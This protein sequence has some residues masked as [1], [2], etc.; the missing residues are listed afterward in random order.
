MALAYGSAWE[1]RI[2]DNYFPKNSQYLINGE[3]DQKSALN[4]SDVR[5]NV[6]SGVCSQI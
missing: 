5:F 1:L 3:S 2:F 6:P 4:K